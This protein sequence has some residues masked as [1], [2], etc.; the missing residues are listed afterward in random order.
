M[1]RCVVLARGYNFA[2]ASELALKLKELTYLMAAAYSS[3]DF[4]HGPIASLDPGAAALLVMPTG[5]AYADMLALA[6]DLRERGADLAVISDTP[7]ALAL[8]AAPLPLDAAHAHPGMAEP[9]DRRDPRPSARAA[10]GR[11]QGTGS[12]CAAWTA[13][14][15]A[16]PVGC[17]A[18]AYSSPPHD[19]PRGRVPRTAASGERSVAH[20]AEA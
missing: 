1:D 16:H 7:E 5:A 20:S 4:R 19:C 6:A 17:R 18:R 10:A 13:Q 11:G 9:R 12:R 8:A 3:A 2:T 14:G 15:H